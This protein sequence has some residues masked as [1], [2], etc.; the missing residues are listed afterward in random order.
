MSAEWVSQL[1]FS[2][3]QT[4]LL[5]NIVKTAQMSVS[6]SQKWLIHKRE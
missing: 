3:G 5:L 1:G 2:K 6:L 4:L